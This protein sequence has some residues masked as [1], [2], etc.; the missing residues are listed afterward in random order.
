MDSLVLSQCRNGRDEGRPAIEDVLFDAWSHALEEL[1]GIYGTNA[2]PKRTA[3]TVRLA[4]EGMPGEGK[5]GGAYSNEA[6]VHKPASLPT[7]QPRKRQKQE[8]FLK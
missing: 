1:Y 2:T 4:S 7:S 8:V 5:S 3:G 6:A